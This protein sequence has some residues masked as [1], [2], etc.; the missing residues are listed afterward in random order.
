MIIINSGAYVI[1]ELQAEYGKIPPCMLPLG[2][3]RLLEHQISAIRH[4]LGELDI[5]VSLPE[6]YDLNLSDD[7]LIK[8]AGVKVVR[9]PDGFTLA[10][11]V[12]YVLNTQDEYHI[13]QIV[14][15]MHGDTLINGIPTAADVIGTSTTTD[16]YGW[17]YEG[18]PGHDK[19]IWCGFFSFSSPRL[20][21]QSLTLARGDFV[22]AIKRYSKKT[23][24]L[25]QEVGSWNDLG[26]VNTYFKSRASITT[27]RA[28]NSLLIADG[29]VTKRG[30]PN[31]KIQAEAKWFAA[32]PPA[33]KRFTP[34]L[35]DC[36][37]DSDGATY[38]CLEYLSLSPLNEVFVHG[39]NPAFFWEK[40]FNIFKDVF[41][42]MRQAAPADIDRE[43]LRL[44]AHAL[45]NEKTHRRLSEIGTQGIFDPQSPF[46]Y[47]GILLP[48]LTELA[49]ICIDKTLILPN[50]LSVLHGDICFSN[51][52]YDSR[53]EMIK[54][55]DPRG[56][57]E[58]GEFSIFGD[59]K[60][61]LAKFAHSVLGLYDLI[62]AGRYEL[63]KSAEGSVVLD[64]HLD[65]RLEEIQETFL[66]TEFTPAV[67]V[68]DVMPAVVL[69]FISMIPLHF[70]RPDRQE[71]MIANAY[72][73][74]M[75]YC[76]GG[77]SK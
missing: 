8:T 31:R 6:S 64:F 66:A 18:T 19:L 12:L 20:L 54:I 44:D 29:M 5:V 4:A 28:F 2:N 59:Q 13:E 68:R 27:Q 11:S 77:G 69:L 32:L 51:V 43:A 50:I 34:Q 71:A 1:P 42:K 36:K 33:L 41:D 72:R 67:S 9:V 58:A 23:P 74:F 47:D 60:Y 73:I 15:L 49:D 38:Y 21:T 35:I 37:L 10:E 76:S 40:I 7:L 17:E 61:D 30:Q 57:T 70:D 14:R 24:L 56:M 63:N 53:S 39:K 62:I 65:S 55:L 25:G 45:Y 3:K 26:H 22:E 52:L 48:S 46:M 16:D 75:K